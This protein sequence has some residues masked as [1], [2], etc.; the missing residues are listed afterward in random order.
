MPVVSIHMVTYNSAATVEACIRS[1]FAQRDIDYRLVVVDNASS[2]ET[3]ALTRALGVEV[4]VNSENRGYAAAHNQALR[5]TDS[6]YVLTLNPDVVL[7]PGFL[8]SMVAALESNPRAGSASG[9][10]RR[11]DRL[12]EQS[13]IIDSAGLFMRRNRRQGLRCEGEPAAGC[14][15]TP[16]FIFGPD[17]AAALYRRAMLEDIAVFG[18]IFDEDFFMHK[19]DVDI[20]W[21]AQLRGWQ[22]LFVPDAMALHIR[23][24]RPGQRQN[25][26]DDL[27]FW[28]VRNRYLLL[29][30]NE[31][32]GGLLRDLIFVAGYDVA[33]L[34]YLLV[35]ERRT[36]AAL[37]SAWLLRRK[38]LKK[39]QVI[40]ASRSAN[41]KQLAP[42]FRG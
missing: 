12:E 35:F 15:R 2:D 7:Q 29:L 27:R 25:V 31:I 3:V 20:C 40:Q 37:R 16:A 21:R 28:G 18:E 11:V 23:T 36:L 8:A 41:W 9:C 17:G 39:R 10:L 22:S 33:I 42:L 5:Q 4:T 26:S 14:A 1:V 6:V 32:W 19:E 38:M 34:V 13:D 24:F 30:K